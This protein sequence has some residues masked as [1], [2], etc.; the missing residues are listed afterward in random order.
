MEILQLLLV[1][2]LQF[3]DLLCLPIIHLELHLGFLLKS[4]AGHLLKQAQNLPSLLLNSEVPDVKWEDIGGLENVKQILRE[5][6]ELPFRMPEKFEMDG[7]RPTI[8][9]LLFGPPGTGKT[10]LA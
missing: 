7:I 10:L 9:I 2:A 8:G 1:F 3:L 6:V 5:A 4:K